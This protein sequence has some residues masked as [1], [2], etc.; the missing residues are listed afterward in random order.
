MK[1]EEIFKGIVTN[2]PVKSAKAF[3]EGVRE[4]LDSALEV[5]K[6]GLTSSIFN[7]TIEK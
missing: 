5:R 7:K 1:A 2:N 6:V 4:K 3:G